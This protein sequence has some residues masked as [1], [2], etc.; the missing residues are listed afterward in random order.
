MLMAVWKDEIRNLNGCKTGR[1]S[2]TA[3]SHVAMT[4]SLLLTF[5]PSIKTFCVVAGCISPD[6]LA[7]A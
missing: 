3:L 6:P 2:F 7:S 5:D 4:P 1:Q